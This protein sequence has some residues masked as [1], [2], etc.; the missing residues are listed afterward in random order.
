MRRKIKII[1]IGGRNILCKNGRTNHDRQDNDSHAAHNAHKE[2]LSLPT[3][4]GV[5]AAKGHVIFLFCNA[6]TR[7]WQN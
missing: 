6:L 5:Q 1:A 7:H 4:N 2:K 3:M